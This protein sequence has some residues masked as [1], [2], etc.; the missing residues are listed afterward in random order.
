VAVLPGRFILTLDVDAVRELS[1]PHRL[2]VV[3]HQPSTLRVNGIIG[4]GTAGARAVSTYS[5]VR[6]DID[7]AS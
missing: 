7:T 2:C 6:S 1:D 5:G 3:S 4:A